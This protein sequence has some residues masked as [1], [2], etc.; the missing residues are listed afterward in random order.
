MEKCYFMLLQRHS[1]NR[2]PNLLVSFFNVLTDCFVE[3]LVQ[4][5]H[6]TRFSRESPKTHN[7][8][9]KGYP[10][11]TWHDTLEGGVWWCSFYV[12]DDP[13]YAFFMHAFAW[14]GNCSDEPCGHPGSS[15]GSPGPLWSSDPGGQ[16]GSFCGYDMY[17]WGKLCVSIS[18]GFHWLTLGTSFDHG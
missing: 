6:L 8:R 2:R 4:W 12:F 17:A 7:F 18:R 13:I 1:L 16:S 11:S 10:D 9:S 15:V 3:D 5:D 14:G